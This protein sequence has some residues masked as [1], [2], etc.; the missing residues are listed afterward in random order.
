[1]RTHVPAAAEQLVAESVW[2]LATLEAWSNSNKAITSIVGSTG[3]SVPCFRADLTG[4]RTEAECAWWRCVRCRCCIS[5]SLSL[6]VFG[7]GCATM[8]PAVMCGRCRVPRLTARGS[9]SAGSPD[10]WRGGL[11]NRSVSV[12]AA[13]QCKWHYHVAIP[14]IRPASVTDESVMAA[15]SVAEGSE[16]VRGSAHCSGPPVCTPHTHRRTLE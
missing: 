1:M 3:G 7:S 14:P 8:R 5:M 12:V 2:A 6:Q 11:I 16:P 15:G 13:L 9:P 4:A 10:D